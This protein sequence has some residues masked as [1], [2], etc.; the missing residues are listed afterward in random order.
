[1]ASGR[2]FR[3]FYVEFGAMSVDLSGPI[4]F[5]LAASQEGVLGSGQK[6]ENDKFCEFSAVSLNVVEQIEIVLKSCMVV[7]WV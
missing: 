2:P 6:K 4:T 7:G 5:V 1:M 3:E